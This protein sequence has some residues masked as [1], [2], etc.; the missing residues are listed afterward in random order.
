MGRIDFLGVLMILGTTSFFLFGKVGA[1]DAAGLI[2]IDVQKPK[3]N[4]STFGTNRTTFN[5]FLKS[6]GY[7]PETVQSSQVICS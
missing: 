6:K 1:K 7:S 3:A 5:E 2:E 4:C